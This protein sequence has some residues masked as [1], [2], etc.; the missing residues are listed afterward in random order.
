MEEKDPEHAGYIPGGLYEPHVCMLDVVASSWKL[1][2][3]RSCDH[4]DHEPERVVMS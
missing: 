4:H 3:L 1:F 2:F